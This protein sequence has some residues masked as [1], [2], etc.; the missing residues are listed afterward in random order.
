MDHSIEI[1]RTL[2]YLSS[3][4][5]SLK[6]PLGSRDNPARICRDLFNCEHRMHDGTYWIDPNLGCNADSIEVTCNFTALGQTCL[7]PV[8]VSK[9]EFGVG[10]IQMNFIHLLSTQAVQRITI[11]CLNTPVW[12]AGAS[13]RPTASAVIFK[14]WNG[15]K[16]RAG[17]LLE[18][19]VPLDECW[20]KDGRWHQT[21]F[22][23][24]TQDL[25]L[26]PIV[27]VHNLPKSEHG[28]RYYLEV[29]PVCF[30]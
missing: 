1:F 29:G 26:L 23:F 8:T 14:A 2:Q 13:L 6:H 7:K 15:E 9:L 18:P 17:D 5:Q 20:I 22:L 11:H 16:I 25:N 30:L 19:L 24:Q 28:A 10:R 21:K 3:L 12:A 4:V 27:D